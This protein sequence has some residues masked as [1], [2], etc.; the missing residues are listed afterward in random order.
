MRIVTRAGHAVNTKIL[1]VKQF[2]HEEKSFGLT[3]VERKSSA[4]TTV[5]GGSGAIGQ[6]MIGRG[7]GI[8][9][10]RKMESK[11]LMRNEDKM[12]GRRCILWD[13]GVVDSTSQC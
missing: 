9:K 8:Q 13:L 7:F 12:V 1:G 10:L 2:V 3:C 6:Q 11:I 4:S 5:S